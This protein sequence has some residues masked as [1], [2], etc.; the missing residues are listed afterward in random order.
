MDLVP[1][2]IIVLYLLPESVALIRPQLEAALRRGS[3]L[4]AN[5]WGPKGMIPAAK[6][7]AGF[8]N[9]VTLLRYDA[10]SLGLARV[11][12]GA[13]GDGVKEDDEKTP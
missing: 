3:V 6:R 8:G 5:T 1:A 9:N 10:S 7:V 2:S 4:I 13:D 11:G 12:G